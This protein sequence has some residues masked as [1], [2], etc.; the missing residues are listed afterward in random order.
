[1]EVLVA[2]GALGVTAIVTLLVIRSHL[3]VVPP[4][5]VAVL[6]GRAAP[7]AGG[8]VRGYRLV[9]AGRTLRFPLIEQLDWMDLT[10]MEV[11]LDIPSLDVKAGGHVAVSG[12]ASVKVDGNEPLVHNAV[13]RFLGTSSEQVRMVAMQT[14]EGTIREVATRLT[15]DDLRNTEKLRLYVL[16]EADHSFSKLGLVVD[17]VKLRV[18]V[19][20]EGA[21]STSDSATQTTADAA[22]RASA[23]PADDDRPPWAKAKG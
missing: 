20:R 18:D 14:L 6:S 1:M 4:N 8:E 19:R 12:V 23:A 22:A 21:A 15:V 2:L 17:S 7:Q 11:E 13:E 5:R 10:H 16:E 9:K 3:V